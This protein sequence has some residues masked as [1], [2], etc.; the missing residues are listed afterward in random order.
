MDFRRYWLA[1]L[2]AGATAAVAIV[3]PGLGASAAE[4]Y[5]PQL[6]DIMNATQVRHQKLFF[7]GR[8]RNWE[9]AAYETRLLRGNLRDAAVLYSGIPITSVTTLAERLQAVDDAIEAKDAK[10]FAKA[11]GE[12]TTG[13]NQCHQSLDRPYIVM[14]QPSDQ[15][16]GNQQF[17]PPGER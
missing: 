14:Q 11:F 7:A 4:Q 12:L 2:V 17:T 13:C 16:F 3:Q 6:G 1:A 5:V 9:L 15:P 10:R 8:A